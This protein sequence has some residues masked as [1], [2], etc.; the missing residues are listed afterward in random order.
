M[1]DLQTIPGNPHLL[2]VKSM[3]LGCN[4]DNVDAKE[5]YKQCENNAKYSGGDLKS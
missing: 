2:S 1:H 4:S 5:I 3:V